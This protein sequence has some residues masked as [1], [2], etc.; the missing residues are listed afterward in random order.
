MNIHSRLETTVTIILSLRAATFLK[1]LKSYKRQEV[2]LIYANGH[3]IIARLVSHIHFS[4]CKRFAHKNIFIHLYT[5]QL[6]TGSATMFNALLWLRETRA[7]INTPGG[8]RVAETKRYRKCSR[9]FRRWYLH[10]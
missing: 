9:S 2:I 7:L 10:C 3:G 1:Q 4:T 5:I 6:K 8:G